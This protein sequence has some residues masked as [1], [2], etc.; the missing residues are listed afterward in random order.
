M[1]EMEALKLALSKEQSSVKYY[2]ELLVK[3]P[4]LKDLFYLLLNEE[5]KHV[6]MIEEKIAQ[7][8]K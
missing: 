4:V 8:Y 2:Q 5:Q 7:L 1:I 6:M 3:H